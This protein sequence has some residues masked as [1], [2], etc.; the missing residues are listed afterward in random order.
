MSTK[1]LFTSLD[2]FKDFEILN[3][4]RVIG[5]AADDG[6]HLGEGDDDLDEDEM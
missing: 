6:G 3:Q 4:T 2:N 1:I 5:G